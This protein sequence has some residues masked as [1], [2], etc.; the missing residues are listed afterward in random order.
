MPPPTP[1]PPSIGLDGGREIIDP[2]LHHGGTFNVDSFFNIFFDVSVTDVDSR[3]GRVFAG[4]SDGATITFQDLAST[5]QTSTYVA[6][7]D[8]NAPN[9]D[10]VPQTVGDPFIGL[11]NLQ[12]PLGADFNGNL[13]LDK[14]LLNLGTFSVDNV[15]S[16]AELD[17]SITSNFTAG[18]VIQG[19]V[20]DVNTDP[21]FQVGG[22]LP[23]GLPDPATFGGTGSLNADLLNT[24][25]PEPASSSLLFLGLAGLFLRRRR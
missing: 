1:P 6:I 13:L 5:L 7:F 15:T 9:F 25:V 18:G 8:Q 17:G 16:L 22:L 14:V 2:A 11:I 21:P 10:L 23:N 12:I 19:S 20:Q 3:P 24:V 4:Q